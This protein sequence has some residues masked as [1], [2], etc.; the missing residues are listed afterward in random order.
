MNTN[1]VDP[2]N[3]LVNDHKVEPYLGFRPIRTAN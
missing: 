1:L 3:V 2:L